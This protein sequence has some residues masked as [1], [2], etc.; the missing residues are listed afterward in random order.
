MRKL[1]AAAFL[2][3]IAMTGSTSAAST[4][5]WYCTGDGIKSWTSDTGAK[6]AQGWTYSGDRTSYKAAGHCAKG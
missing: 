1:L 6:D 3:A 2:S 4:A 5:H